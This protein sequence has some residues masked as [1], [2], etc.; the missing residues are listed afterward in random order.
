MFRQI[1][2]TIQI[3][4]IS[5][6]PIAMVPCLH[7]NSTDINRNFRDAEPKN[8]ILGL[9]QKGCKP[10]RDFKL[11]A[12]MYRHVGTRMQ[13]S[14][15]SG[16]LIAMI[17]CLHENNT[18]I[19]RKFYGCRAKKYN[20]W[21]GVKSLRTSTELQIAR[22][23]ESPYRADNANFRNFEASFRHGTV[24]APKLYLLQKEALGMQ[25]PKILFFGWCKKSTNLYGASNYPHSGIAI[26]G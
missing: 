2:P 12:F 14:V 20:F 15:T 10:R 7:Q 22:I 4:G 13:I 6:L 17:P 1:G 5:R 9:L 8:I 23:H 3:S 24:F 25:R 18:Y 16:L 21:A 26:M 19:K 11:T